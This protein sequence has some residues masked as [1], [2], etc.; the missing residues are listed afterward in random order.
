MS[1]KEIT[2]REERK[3]Y[4]KMTNNS[5]SPA[6]HTQTITEGKEVLK[7]FPKAKEQ[8]SFAL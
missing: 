6:G 2:K 4:Y 1:F 8:D 5:K 3:K 7:V